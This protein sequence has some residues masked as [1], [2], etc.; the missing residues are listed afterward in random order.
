[1]T[2]PRPLQS[3]RF[4][5]LSATGPVAIA[6]VVYSAVPECTTST[7]RC[8]GI[9]KSLTLTLSY[10]LAYRALCLFSLSLFLALLLSLSSSNFFFFFFIFFTSSRPPRSNLHPDFPSFSPSR[11]FFLHLLF[12]ISSRP[13]LSSFISHHLTPFGFFCASV[14]K[15]LSTPCF[16]HFFLDSI[17]NLFSVLALLHLRFFFYNYTFRTRQGDPLR[18]LDDCV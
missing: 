3:C 5:L 12:L 18:F 7:P 6:A 1:M 2:R 17:T 8:P 13:L 14:N 15:H 9:R 16:L 4:L 10:S 11:F